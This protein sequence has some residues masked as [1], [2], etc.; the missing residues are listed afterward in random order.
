MEMQWKA[1]P[2]QYLGCAVRQV[3]NQEQ[4]LELRLTEGMPD[5]GRVISA[6]GQPQLREKQWR[7]DEIGVSG[8]ITAWVLY[9]PEDGSQPRCVEGWIPFQGK[10]KLPPDCREGTIRA[11]VRLRSMDARALSS[12]KMLVRASIALLAEALEPREAA[13]SQPDEVPEGVHLLRQ[14]YPVCLAREAGEK[15]FAVEENLPL[16]AGEG[17]RLLCCRLS[18][19]LTEQA[20]T[21]SRVVLRGSVRAEYLTCSEDGGLQSG[22]Q[23]VPFA[24]FAELERDYDKEATAAITLSFAA[25]ECSLEGDGLLIK[26]ELIAQY[27]IQDR[28]LL[29]ITEDAYSPQRS[30]TPTVCALALPVVLDKVQETMDAELE[31]PQEAQSV[32]DVAFWPDQPVHYRENELLVVEVPGTFQT[33][34]YDPE[35]NLQSDLRSWA[36]HWQLPAQED[37]HFVISAE[38]TAPPTAMQL[39]GKQRLRT[40]LQLD[41]QTGAVQNIPMVTG[42]EVGEPV[43]PDP[44]RPSLIICRPE[45]KSLWELAKGCGSTVEAIEKANGLTGEPDPE[46]MLLIPVV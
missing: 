46:N 34:Y 26:C 40:E 18:A 27:V 30:V 29:P 12:R 39:G 31:L 22:A 19:Q 20:V 1:A 14:T 45:G 24:Q 37:C 32:V 10:W 6:W 9:I 44:D 5:I 16:S 25:A 8:G 28:C 7:S 13:I 38:T 33:L 4:T 41:V 23:E 3:Q 43:T 36:G 11:D 2:C 35:G 17:T 21:G 42:L 15:L